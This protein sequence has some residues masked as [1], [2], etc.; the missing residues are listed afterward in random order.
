MNKKA[1]LLHE[2]VIFIVLNVIFFVMMIL[3]ISMKGSAIYIAEEET[4]KQI[5]LII[6]SAKPGTQIEINLKDYFEK[7]ENEG[8]N[9][10][11]S[12]FIDNEKN[13]VVAKGSSDSF[14]DYSYFNDVNIKFNI[15]G[16]Y[17]I[18]EVVEWI[19]KQMKDY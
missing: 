14:Y 1:D 5:A 15:K 8:M 12:I 6:D 3:F 2:N 16:D 9:R 18:L 7:V 13:I 11:R 17:L 4:A 19:K 10:E